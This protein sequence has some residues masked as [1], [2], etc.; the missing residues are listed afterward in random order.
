MNVP[1]GLWG[2]TIRNPKFLFVKGILY[3]YLNTTDQSGPYHD[4]DGIIYGGAD[5]YFQNYVY[6]SGWTYNNRIIGTPFISLPTFNSIGVMTS[7][8]N[9]VQVHHI[10][11]EG[12]IASYEYRILSSFSK[13]YGNYGNYGIVLDEDK[14]NNT[15]VMLEIKKQFP[16]LYNIEFGC[17]VAADYGKLYGNS[18]GGLFSIR[19]RGDLFHY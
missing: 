18:V 12:D 3:E 19:K 17:T 15:S 8:N 10:G 11:I 6:H 14:R 4:K 7:L 1:D 9:R 5:S 16:K 2:I 13:N